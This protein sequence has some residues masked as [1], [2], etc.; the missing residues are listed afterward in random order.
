MLDAPW[1]RAVYHYRQGEFV[2]ALGH[3]QVAFEYAK[4]RAGKYQYDL[5][6]QFTEVAAKNDSRRRFKKGIEWA[7]YLDIKVRWL[8]NEPTEEKLNYVYGMLKIARYD[9]Q[10]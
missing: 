3:Y 8:R 6:N 2:A 7:Q 10:L 9:H 5:V 1:L 4:Y